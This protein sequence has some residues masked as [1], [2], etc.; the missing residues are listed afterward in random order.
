MEEE[1]KGAKQV[2]KRKVDLL[3][4]SVAQSF[5]FISPAMSFE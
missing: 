4:V 1:I 3:D 5:S 2:V